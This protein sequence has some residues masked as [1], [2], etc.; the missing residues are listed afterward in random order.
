MDL[1][2]AD[3]TRKDIGAIRD[4]TF[5]LAF[6]VDE[7]DF[8]CQIG[9][10]DHCC[11]Q[12][13]YLYIENTEYGGIIDVLGVDTDSDTIIYRGRTWHGILASKIL[14]PNAGEDYLVLS[15]DANTVLAEIIVRIDLEGLF[16]ASTEE[17]GI[18]IQNYA[19]NRYVDAYLGIRKMLE[20]H[21][22]KLKL[23]YNG[24][25]VIL[26]AAKLVDYSKDDEWDSSQMGFN[27][28]QNKNPV[29]HIVCLGKG[30]LAGRQVL[31]LYMDAAGNIS[32]EQTLT[33]VGE[34]TETY[35]NP[36][37]ESLDELEK[38]GRERLEEAF[39][40][41]EQ[42]ETSFDSNQ[43]YDIGDIVGAREEVTGM[44]IARPIVKKIVTIDK[45]GI[46]IEHK[47]GE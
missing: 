11:K 36:N 14:C 12:D 20:A 39:K 8:Q 23:F 17:S 30:E 27:V 26:S 46:N 34:V 7:N 44:Y 28:S 41:A 9:R 29:N 24:E 15:G 45:N 47:V 32:Y 37:T 4:S 6:G 25:K 38:G 18:E 5:D 16:E 43:D 19:M 22:S 40:A 21:S 10:A 2:Y 42:L 35:D 3:A 13:Y 31:H 1:I 33:G